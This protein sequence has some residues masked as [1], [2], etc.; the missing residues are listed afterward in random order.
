MEQNSQTI[1]AR[2][3]K[4]HSQRTSHL[5]RARQ[6]SALTIPHL[7]PPESSD[8]N[9]P[10][11]TPF[12]AQ[13]AQC[14][15]HLASKFWLALFPPGVSF[16]KLGLSRPAQAQ[17]E[18]VNQG[19]QL[20]VK[21]QVEE[22]FADI[23]NTVLDYIE[24]NG[25]RSPSFRAI[26]LYVTTGNACVY[27][28]PQKDFHP[29]LNSGAG[30]KVFR[31]DQYAVARDPLGN[32]LELVIREQVSP[33]VLPDSVVDLLRN[34]DKEKDEAKVDLFTRVW[35]KDGRYHVKQAANE[36]DIP[37]TEGVYK[38]EDLPWL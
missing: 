2:W 25:F 18:A 33:K 37:G 6:C 13:G 15:N 14:V 26:R 34:V 1:Q 17:L 36:V 27:V 16:F 5:T 12:S 21:T 20:S 30:L 35:L 31:L 8:Y 38:P 10:L 22:G 23:E 29:W 9:T 7:L 4:L 19:G 24:N 32:L 28:P 3:T 11:P